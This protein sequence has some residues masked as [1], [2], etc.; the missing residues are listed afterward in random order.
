MALV[1]GVLPVQT[2]Q[3]QGMSDVTPTTLK[4]AKDLKIAKKDEK[5]IITA[6]VPFAKKGK[7]NLIHIA[8]ME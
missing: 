6:G 3:L 7:T 1:W 5:V 2:K 4:I 8:V